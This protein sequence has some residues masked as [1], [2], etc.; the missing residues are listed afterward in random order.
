MPLHALVGAVAGGPTCLD[1]LVV[2]Y[3]TRPWAKTG[4]ALKL[5]RMISERKDIYG[6]T[7]AVAIVL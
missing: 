3:V 1:P 2:A 5:K 7:I 6:V 4:P